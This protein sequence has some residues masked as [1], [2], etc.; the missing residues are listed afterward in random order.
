MSHSPPSPSHRAYVSSGQKQP[1]DQASTLKTSLPSPQGS[2]NVVQLFGCDSFLKPSLLQS[3]EPTTDTSPLSV[4]R[5]KGQ[6]LVHPPAL[7]RHLRV[8]A[9]CLCRQEMTWTEDRS[10]ARHHPPKLVVHISSLQSLMLTC[11]CGG[12]LP[13]RIGELGRSLHEDRHRS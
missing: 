11:D 13:V 5:G 6:P 1:M 3:S 9:N 12:F 2:C 7:F 4:S 8:H 10:K